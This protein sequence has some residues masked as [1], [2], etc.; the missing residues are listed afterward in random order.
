MSSVPAPCYPFVPNLLSLVMASERC[1]WPICNPFPPVPSSSSILVPIK[2]F[3]TDDRPLPQQSTTSEK[4]LSALSQWRWACRPVGQ[5]EGGRE[6][7]EKHVIL[8]NLGENRRLCD[9]DGDFRDHQH[10][11]SQPAV[12]V[13]I[14]ILTAGR[15]SPQN[16]GFC[17]PPPPRG[18]RRRPTYLPESIGT[19]TRALSLAS[20]SCSGWVP[21]KECCLPHL[22]LRRA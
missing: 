17:P 7:P 6:E 21:S 10:P 8:T 1:D 22:A 16:Q 12:L 11:R 18:T 4:T 2:M 5:H 20:Q 9:R 15:C 3:S 14:R 13:E 19:R